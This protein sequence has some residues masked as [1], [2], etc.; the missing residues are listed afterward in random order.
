MHLYIN[1]RNSELKY[2]KNHGENAFLKT[3]II[4]VITC[5]KNYVVYVPTLTFKGVYVDGD[6]NKKVICLPN[7]QMLYYITS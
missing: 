7:K 3:V 5:K 1:A 4:M 6:K 2:N